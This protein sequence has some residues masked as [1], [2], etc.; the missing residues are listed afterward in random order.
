MHGWRSAIVRNGVRWTLATGLATVA[1]DSDPAESGASETDG[2]DGSSDSSASTGPHESMSASMSAGTTG[3][4]D[5]SDSTPGSS[6]TAPS[7]TDPST[8][9]PSTTDPSTTAGSDTTDTTSDSDDME[10]AHPDVR[11]YIFG[12]SL[13]LHSPT[14]NVPIWL[15]ALADEAGYSYGMSG[16]Y[17]FADTHAT[18]LPPDP[19]WGIEGVPAIWNDGD[20]QSFADV[21]FNTVLFTEANFRQYFPPTE[22]DPDGILPE[23][24]VQ[25]TTAVFDWVAD[26]QPGVRYV[27]YEN[28][29]D[30]GSF[31]DADFENGFPTSAELQAYHAFTQ[32][33]FHQWWLD[34]H[35]GMMAAR[36]D[37]DIRMIPVGPVLAGLSTTLQLET[38]V[39]ALYEDNAPHGRPTLYYLAGLVTYMGLYSSLPPPSYVPPETIHA[40]V[41]ERHDEVVQFIWD[42]LQAFDDARGN[43]RVF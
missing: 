17:G 9:A 34:Y 5:S 30:M 41:R 13:I 29:P 40:S 33:E 32:G 4:T 12:H 22:P 3:N 2:D 8:T 43:S 6:A 16:Q 21:Q 37:L 10:P 38:P 15:N 14:A 23:S 42:E 20:G 31:T 28:W 27:L 39:E 7:T 18:E 24:S 25:S 26:A 1:C 35:D 36:P 19:N 11:N